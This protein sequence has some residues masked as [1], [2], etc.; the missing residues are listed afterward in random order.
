VTQSKT[1]AFLVAVW[2]FA[3]LSLVA[4]N[5]SPPQRNEK[6]LDMAA[7]RLPAWRARLERASQL[8][9]RRARARPEP[10]RKG[11]GS[12]LDVNRVTLRAQSA[13]G[14]MKNFA[15]RHQLLR[16]ESGIE[17]GDPPNFVDYVGGGRGPGRMWPYYISAVHKRFAGRSSCG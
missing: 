11:R 16:R 8:G 3:A 7:K 14:T 17:Y 1:L 5:S 4:Q 15:R 9:K 10:H 13:S 12:L 2:M 6:I